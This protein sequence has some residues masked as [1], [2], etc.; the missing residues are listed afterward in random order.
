MS[1]VSATVAAPIAKSILEDAIAALEIPKSTAGV[2]K[3]YRY[4]DTKYETVSNVVGMTPKEARE[5]LSSFTIEYSGTGNK[6]ISM[7][8]EAGSRIAVGSTV[9]LMLENE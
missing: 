5:L 4:Y 9:R 2:E 3:E 8:P 7:S 6:I 1:F